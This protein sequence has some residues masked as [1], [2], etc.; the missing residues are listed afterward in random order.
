MRRIPIGVEDFKRMIERDFYYIDKTE[1]I[2]DVLSD[3][4]T[5]Y[6]RP[7]RFGKTLNMSMLYYF[8]SNKEDGKIFDGLNITQNKEAMKHMNQYPVV[9]ISLKD[10]K[11]MSMDHQMSK[12]RAI[13]SDIISQNNELLTSDKLGE[14]EKKLMHKLY[15][16]ESSEPALFDALLNISKCLKQHYGKNTVILIDEYDVPLQ[17]AYYNGYYKEMVDFMGGV[18]SSVLK[19]NTALEKGILTG[20]LRISRESIFTGLNN[21]KVNSI[22][23]GTQSH[24]FGFTQGEIDKLLCDYG[25]EEYKEE[26]REWYDG[27]LFG[28]T[29][30]YNPWSSIMY[31]DKKLIKPKET[32][33]SFWAN[34]SSNQLVID[35]IQRADDVMRKEFEELMRGKP[36]TKYLELELT[37]KDMDDLNNV[38]SFLFLTGYLKITRKVEE[39]IY[40]LV[41]PN[42]EVREIYQR[43]FMKYF[44][45]YVD[46]KK[47][48]FVSA[49]VKKDISKAQ[50]IL[51]E[52]LFKHI[53]YFDNHENFYHGLLTGLLANYRIQSNKEIGEGRPDIVVLPQRP[54]ETAIVIECKQSKDYLEIERDSELGA[55][56]I[57]DNK[58]M[59][60][61]NAYYGYKEV[62]GYGI[63]F[64]KKRCHITLVE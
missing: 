12:F 40:E 63:S 32:A 37:Y 29:D 60:G 17:S 44:R 27:Y 31:V 9:F 18:L 58:Y 61:I 39:H 20:C 3:E 28:E 6:T 21:F 4:I 15:M 16:Q 45:S 62:V 51:S 49:L 48:D 46:N 42:R 57:K 41:I 7:R 59:E 14:F 13:I 36:I 43:S 35:Y 38:Y 23:D 47:S 11:R 33:I 10:M 52:I 1:W 34:T 53:S 25:L 55:E 50:D 30:I 19:S 26:V 5:L 54:S 8:F 2:N 22:V 56:Q 24:A 64:Y